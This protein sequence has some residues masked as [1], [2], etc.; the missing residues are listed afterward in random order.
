MKHARSVAAAAVLGLGLWTATTALAGEHPTKSEHPTKKSEHPTKAETATPPG[1]DAAA[2]EAWQAYMTP[3]PEQAW[4]AASEGTWDAKI[5]MWMDPK[6]PAEES[7]GT[8]VVTMI[9]GGRYQ[10]SISTG[11]FQGQT[12][13]GI[14]TMAY[15]N[16]L[17]KYFSTWIDSMG[18]GIMTSS[19]TRDASG[20]TLT[21]EGD[22][23]DPMKGK[24]VHFKMT[25]THVDKDH[26]TFEMWAPDD[27]GKMYRNMEI[28]YT[29]RATATN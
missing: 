9:L 16:G 13:E 2:M 23:F 26:M 19:G 6:A 12:F 3:G 27:A 5:K 21:L 8:M 29:R 20:K 7:T 14:G 22:S 1:I 25:S 11:N 18:T 15:D 28:T 10:Q 24:V 4:L 17:K